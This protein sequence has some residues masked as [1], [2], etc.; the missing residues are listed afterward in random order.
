[1]VWSVKSQTDLMNQT[2]LVCSWYIFL[3]AQTPISRITTP[4]PKAGMLRW[5][6][7]DLSIVMETLTSLS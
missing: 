2:C 5:T 4:G 3:T 7:K 6:T 1:M